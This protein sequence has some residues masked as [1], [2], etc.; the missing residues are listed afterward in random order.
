MI[1]KCQLRKYSGLFN[2][3]LLALFGRSDFILPDLYD[4][5]DISR[6]EL[7]TTS[8]SIIQVIKISGLRL[9]LSSLFK[10]LRAC[11]DSSICSLLIKV[12]L[13]ALLFGVSFFEA[14]FEDA[15]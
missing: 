2:N 4:Q 13:S 3:N 6:A 12:L 10:L 5:P 8:V 14:G 7:A 1:K 9:F 11:F 15:I